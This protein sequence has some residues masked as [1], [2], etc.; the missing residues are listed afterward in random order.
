MGE[1]TNKHSRIKQD[2]IERFQAC[3]IDSRVL[4]DRILA[5]E[6]GVAQLTINRVMRELEWEGYVVRRPRKGTF[7]ANRERR[8]TKD[9]QHYRPPNGD[10]VFAY[11]NFFS[12]TIWSY[13]HAAETQAVKDGVDIVD[14]KLN[15]ESTGKGLLAFI[16]LQEAPRGIL[17]LPSPALLDSATFDK[18]DKIG[19]PVVL[20]CLDERVAVTNNICSVGP[21]WFN[22]GFLSIETLLEAGHRKIAYVQ[23]EPDRAE[24]RLLLDGMKY[25]LRRRDMGVR[26]LVC[27]AKKMKAWA[28]NRESGL[29]MTREL[30][31]N[32]SVTGAFY[33]SIAGVRGALIALR[34]AGLKAPRDFSLISFGP[35]NKEEDYLDPALTT[36]ESDRSDE[37][38][39][40][41]DLILGK[42]RSA[43]K[44]FTT[45]VS[46]KARR[47]VAAPTRAGTRGDR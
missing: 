5:G 26:D 22:V 27:P 20:L 10:I 44:S 4:S 31:R 33:D 43:T 1:T 21:D 14:Y 34:D 13:L 9:Q 46:L 8:V 24:G 40:A 37:I 41:M 23:N 42:T 3:P 17:L 15:P 47:S 6:F 7:L 35:C 39:L 30:L 16:A 45:K 11:P 36:I 19:C 28:D 12:F 2:L 32:R 38:R 25:A 29:Q 18:L